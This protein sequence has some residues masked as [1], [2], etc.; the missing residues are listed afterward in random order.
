MPNTNA[1][2]GDVYV[3]PVYL[4]GPTFTGDPA[5]QPLID[6]GFLLNR[7][8]LANVY[9]SSPEQHIRLGYHP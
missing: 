5:L 3:S 4:A 2:D 1:L 6:H 7:D 8:E 9:V